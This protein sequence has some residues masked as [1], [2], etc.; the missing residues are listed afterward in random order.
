MSVRRGICRRYTLSQ[1][2][3]IRI[4]WSPDPT[5]LSQKVRLVTGPVWPL[6]VE[7]DFPV[8]Q[9]FIFKKA[10]DLVAT[11][12]SRSIFRTTALFSAI[13]AIPSRISIA[14]DFAESSIGSP[15]A[16]VFSAFFFLV[17]K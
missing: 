5:C 12:T 16:F 13:Q 2:P 8:L 1:A 4:S 9:N 15:I 7:R 17:Y 6:K 11:H 3:L 10:D 14:N